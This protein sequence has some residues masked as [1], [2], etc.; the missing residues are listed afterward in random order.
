MQ[1]LLLG[2]VSLA[3]GRHALCFLAGSAFILHQEL[4]ARS[5]VDCQLRRHVE[6]SLL[7]LVPSDLERRRVAGANRCRMSVRCC[8]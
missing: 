4:D 1:I 5:P 8:S 7:S 6:I 2:H 3:K